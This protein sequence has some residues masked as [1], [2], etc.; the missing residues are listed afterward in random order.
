M[1]KEV[2]NVLDLIDKVNPF[3]TYLNDNALSSVKSYIDTGSYVLNAI[4]SGSC[5]GGVPEGRVTVLAGPSMTAK[6]YFIMQLCANAQKKGKV[7]VL[8]DTENAIDP[9]T[10]ERFGLDLAK[11]KY[12]PCITIEQTR[13]AIYKFLSGVRDAKLYG[14]FFIAI[15]SLGNL[16]SE[17]DIN[18]MEKDNTSSDVG[19]KARAM[20]TLMQTCTNL[21][22]MTKTTVVMTNH[23]YDDPSAMYP[24]LEKNMPGG[25]AVVYLPSVTIQLARKPIKD[26]GKNEDAKLSPNQKNYSGVVIK[27]LTVKNRIIKQYIEGEMFISFSNGLD[28]YFGLLDIAVGMG[29]VIQAGATYQLP[30]GTKLGYFSKWRKDENL[31]QNVIIPDLEK[32]MKIAWSYGSELN[33]EPPLEVEEDELMEQK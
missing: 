5:F 13:N 10:A 3:A 28:R 12:V 7:V 30:D 25:R 8:F 14:K 15:D 18:R 27:A 19:T 16:Q 11:V 1:E 26:D 17:M 24:S 33:K 9:E 32:K 6:T 22:A 29:S 2:M 23:V 31:W 21:G 20:K 4:I